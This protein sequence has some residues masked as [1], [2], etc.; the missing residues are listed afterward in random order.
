MELST[1]D[2]INEIRFSDKSG[3][4]L[5]SNWNKGISQLFHEEFRDLAKAKDV[6]HEGIAQLHNIKT[7]DNFYRTKYK[8]KSSFFIL[9]MIYITIISKL[10]CHVIGPHV[11]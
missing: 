5:K 6:I 8:H 1:D 9:L 4:W 10:C 3:D 7:M 11:R 2:G